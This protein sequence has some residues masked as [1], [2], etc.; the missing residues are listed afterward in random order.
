LHP[1][2]SQI[3][4]P[5]GFN[6][7]CYQDTDFGFYLIDTSFQGA[8]D[9]II[10]AQKNVLDVHLAAK[11]YPKPVLSS[12]H[13][14]FNGKQL[15]K[16]QIIDLFGRMVQ[17]GELTHEIDVTVLP[18]GMYFLELMGGGRVVERGQFVRE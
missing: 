8:C 2:A 13:V 6:S 7:R 14:D 15:Q 17:K 11:I 1:V 16:Y 4:Y 5:L 18:S 10:L 3:D 9:S 12:L